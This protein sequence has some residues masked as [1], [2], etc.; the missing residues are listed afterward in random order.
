MG[1]C[2]KHFTKKKITVLVICAAIGLTAAGAGITYAWYVSKADASAT[3]TTSSSLAPAS[4]EF[5][6]SSIAIPYGDYAVIADTNRITGLN[7]KPFV[8]KITYTGTSDTSAFDNNGLVLGDQAVNSLDMG[9]TTDGPQNL[10]VDKDT[11]PYQYQ[12][13]QGNWFVDGNSAQYPER[14]AF[15]NGSGTGW[16]SD[17]WCWLYDDPRPD[18]PAADGNSDSVLTFNFSGTTITVYGRNGSM[19]GSADFNLDG[20]SQMVNEYNAKYS[21]G[22][23]IY[24][25]SGLTDGPHTLTISR[26]NSGGAFCIDSFVCDTTPG[27]CAVT[28][29]VYCD[30]D[31]NVPGE[32]GVLDLG[33]LYAKF[34]GGEQNLAASVKAEAEFCQATKNAL[35]DYF[36]QDLT[37][38]NLD[39]FSKL[40]DK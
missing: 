19:C 18:T 13:D 21:T 20:A 32:P 14:F 26:N 2:K 23:A 15:D 34:V 35:I 39:W 27:Q 36:G 17:D 6:T 24:T 40:P 1:N 28:Y 38:Q 7:G 16:V 30:G 29:Y 12:N 33:P 5:S 22:D 4:L 25:A 31:G 8:C 9:M 10:T 11:Y 3:I 37:G